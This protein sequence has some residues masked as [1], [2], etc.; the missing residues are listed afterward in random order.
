MLMR[1]VVV[2]AVHE[3]VL[4]A[5]SRSGGRSAAAADFEKNMHYFGARYS[6]KV[7]CSTCEES[8]RRRLRPVA[9]R[10]LHEPGHICSRWSY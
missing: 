6:Q 7:S 2:R 3:F 1:S 4:E 10:V 5:K 9:V 8:Q